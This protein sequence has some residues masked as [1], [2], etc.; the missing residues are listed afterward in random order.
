M[1]L[2]VFSY[3]VVASLSTIVS[4]TALT[5]KLQANEKACFFA[6]VEQKGAKIAFYFAVR[7]SRLDQHIPDDFFAFRYNQEA[8]LMW[9]MKS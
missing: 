7:T 4:A 9:I 8:P 5:Y 3:G 6:N 2:A 1:K